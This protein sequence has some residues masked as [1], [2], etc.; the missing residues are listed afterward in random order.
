MVLI[1]Q[2]LEG[3]GREQT[4]PSRSREKFW[5]N[6]EGLGLLQGAGETRKDCSALR[7]RLRKN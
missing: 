2:V 5:T 7:R 4:K 6:G 3:A 1:P